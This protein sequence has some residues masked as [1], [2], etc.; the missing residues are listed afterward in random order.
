MQKYKLAEYSFIACAYINNWLFCVQK[1]DEISF[2]DC[3]T[4]RI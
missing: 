4:D 3:S 1:I 2:S